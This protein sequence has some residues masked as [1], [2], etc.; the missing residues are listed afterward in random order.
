MEKISV[1]YLSF[2]FFIKFSLNHDNSHFSFD[3]LVLPLNLA[4]QHNLWPTIYNT[5]RSSE[6][7][8]ASFKL[9]PDEMNFYDVQLKKI[10]S[11]QLARIHELKKLVIAFELQ[12][13]KA[14]L[15]KGYALAN[16]Y[17][18]PL[19]RISGDTDFLVHTKQTEL[20]LNVLRDSGFNVLPKHEDSHHFVC[21]H[22]IAGRV[23]LHIKL[24]D[25]H[26][27]QYWFKSPHLFEHL[28][29]KQQ[30]TM[31]GDVWVLSENDH[32][33]FLTYHFI[34]HF[35]IKGIGVKQV[36][37]L[38]LFMR[39]HKGIVDWE[40]YRVNLQKRGY[41][42]LIANVVQIGIDYL[43]FKQEDF[44]FP[45]TNNHQLRDQ[46][47]IDLIEGGTFGQILESRSHFAINLD[48][49]LEKKYHRSFLQRMKQDIF[50]SKT[51]FTNKKGFEYLKYFSFLLPIAWIQR[52]IFGFFKFIKKPI[53]YG[54]TITNNPLKF[55][56]AAK[57][58]VQLIKNLGI[59]L[60]QVEEV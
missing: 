18:Q 32:L 46:L 20:A 25:T 48:V 9:K 21:E 13:V 4:S 15:L 39:Q 16:L 5:I 38:L 51:H 1:T 55:S 53:K 57:K 37:D 59:E 17:P 40:T 27:I 42:Q 52:I 28:T 2:L 44:L 22:P 54:R 31:I 33:H 23:E 14:I 10:I 24:Y 47:L 26:F 12:G 50:V 34:K 11:K 58:R 7:L 29:F 43:G 36:I 49:K 41:D 56:S 30:Q 35:L 6:K 45:T 60:N 8:L 19:L 3:N